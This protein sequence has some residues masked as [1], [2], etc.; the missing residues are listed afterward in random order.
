VEDRKQGR[1]DAHL[2]GQGHGQARPKRRANDHGER[3]QEV[4]RFAGVQPAAPGAGP[5]HHPGGPD[6]HRN[7]APQTKEEG[8]R[9]GSAPG[10]AHARGRD[11][12]RGA[13]SLDSLSKIDSEI[14]KILVYFNKE[15]S[16]KNRKKGTR[17][18]G[19]IGIMSGG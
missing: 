5:H 15:D 2:Q 9:R 13:G 1:W 18:P 7:R 10:R 17:F 8:A 19:L 3:C 6:R 12:G 11:G 4:G 16:S 14:G